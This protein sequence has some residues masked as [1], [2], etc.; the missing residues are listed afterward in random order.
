MGKIKTSFTK[1]LPFIYVFQI[2]LI[3]ASNIINRFSHMAAIH[4]ESM[5]W[6]GITVFLRI[7]I[8]L[9]VSPLHIGFYRFCFERVNGGRPHILT[10]FD[11]Y[12]SAAGFARSAAAYLISLAAADFSMLM[13]SSLTMFSIFAS[14]DE[15][16]GA[17]FVAAVI[18]LVILVLSELFFLTPYAYAESPSEGL[19]FAIKR[20]VKRGFK[21]MIVLILLK[22]AD[23]G[24][25]ALVLKFYRDDIGYGIMGAD[26]TVNSA[27]GIFNFFLMLTTGSVGK[28][29]EFTAALLIFERERKNML[30]DFFAKLKKG[31]GGEEVQEIAEDLQDTPFIEPYDFC[32]EADERFHDEKVIETEDI[33]GVDILAVLE[34]MDLA[35]DV[36]VDLVVRK[37][38]KKMFDDLAFEIGE[39]VSYEG[40]RSIENSFEEEIDERTFEVSAEITKAS[41]S[42]PFRLT[43]TVG[44]LTLEDE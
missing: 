27:N 12:R 1:V 44:A 19:V 34:E 21:F 40:G 16:T 38:L 14:R 39:F 3:A 8:T 2:V 28:W 24:I 43:V 41:D 20:S 10:V 9:A 32:I 30:K 6:N 5:A 11:F 31:N 17:L 33:R 15:N 13:F 18:A 7:V 36:K 4:S 35:Y 25:N 26:N 23:M 29:I 22:A 37:K 42:E